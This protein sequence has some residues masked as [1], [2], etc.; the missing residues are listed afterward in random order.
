MNPTLTRWLTI[1]MIGVS[2]LGHNGLAADYSGDKEL[3]NGLGYL[4]QTA[5]EAKVDLE[6]TD[7]LNWRKVSP[8]DNLLLLYPQNTIPVADIMRFVGDGGDLIIADDFGSSD[9][10][11]KAIGIKRQ[12]P[13]LASHR[14][15]YDGNEAFPTLSPQGESFLFY[16]VTEVA[17]NHPMALSGDAAPVLSFSEDEH[18]IMQKSIGSGRILVLA[19]PSMLLNDMLR[20]VYGNKQFAA[21]V[22]RVYCDT[23]PCNVILAA[24]NTVHS[25]TYRARSSPMARMADLFDEAGLHVNQVLREIDGFLQTWPGQDMLAWALLIACLLGASAGFAKG[26]LRPA[27]PP[28]ELGPARSPE[29]L[30]VVG[31]A[32][33]HTEADFGVYAR[34]LVAEVDAALLSAGERG[35]E[36]VKSEDIVYAALLRFQ[37]E[38]SSLRALTPPII[39]AERFLRLY[40]DVQAILGTLSRAGRQ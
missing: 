6:T 39:G 11:L 21:N 7:Q 1:S 18:L 13:K 20:R 2:F 22:L 33:A 28:A 31:L 15:F 29:T 5:S 25:G 37:G 16:N 23:E 36:R 8:K 9:A 19:D 30:R 17:T 40:H 24:P 10:L 4:A 12:K 32:G 14:T 34:H 26:R 38:R 27:R 35:I 3:W